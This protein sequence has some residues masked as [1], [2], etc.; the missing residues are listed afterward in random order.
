MFRYTTGDVGACRKKNAHRSIFARCDGRVHPFFRNSPSRAKRI[1][2]YIFF[3]TYARVRPASV[4]YAK[5]NSPLKR[6]RIPIK[7]HRHDM[8]SP[9]SS[10]LSFDLSH[11]FFFF[12]HPFVKS[13]PYI[14]LHV[15][16]LHNPVSKNNNNM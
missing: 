15:S 10:P 9:K 11:F 12:Y 16:L 7:I 3:T 2:T 14:I 4:D 6:D 13:I 5:S 1:V 8:T